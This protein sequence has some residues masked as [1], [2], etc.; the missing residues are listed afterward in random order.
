M[1]ITMEK[2]KNGKYLNSKNMSNQTINI[3]CASEAN[4]TPPPE[5][6]WNVMYYKMPYKWLWQ[7]YKR[8]SP[9]WY[10]LSSRP[11][12]KTFNYLIKRYLLWPLG[13]MYKKQYID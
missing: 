3:L 7:K 9:W 11:K 13:I 5:K 1:S 8:L 10:I 2:I 12:R 6:P 4:I